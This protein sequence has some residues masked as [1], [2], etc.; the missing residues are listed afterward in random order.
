M[1]SKTIRHDRVGERN[2]NLKRTDSK[3]TLN[4]FSTFS[5]LIYIFELVN[6]VLLKLYNE[7]LYFYYHSMKTSLIKLVSRITMK[8]TP[9]KS[10]SLWRFLFHG[11]VFLAF[12]LSFCEMLKLQHFGSHLLI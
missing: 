11:G 9:L 8:R 6:L 2:W 1:V 5:C 7:L 3:A 10:E 12:Y 4:C